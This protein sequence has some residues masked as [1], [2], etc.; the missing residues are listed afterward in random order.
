MKSMLENIPTDWASNLLLGPTPSLM[1]PLRIVIGEQQL[2]STVV[3]HT[4]PCVLLILF[5]FH[6]SL[7][8][9]PQ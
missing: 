1:P 8:K 9:I 3:N 5:Y 7:V 2:T 6:H 4:F